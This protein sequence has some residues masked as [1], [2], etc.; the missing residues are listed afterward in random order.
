MYKGTILLG[1]FANTTQSLEKYA[2]MGPGTQKD[3]LHT[4]PNP[5]TQP[6]AVAASAPKH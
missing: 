6:Q 4:N 5:I 1:I 2:D 3:D